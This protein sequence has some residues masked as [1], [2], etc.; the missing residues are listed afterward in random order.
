M[1]FKLVIPCAVPIAMVFKFGFD[2]QWNF[3]GNL[4]AFLEMQTVTLEGYE[5]NNGKKIPLKN[6]ENKPTKSNS[7]SI[8]GTG[9]ASF[10]LLPNASVGVQFGGSLGA[11]IGVT[12]TLNLIEFKGE[13]GYDTKMPGEVYKKATLNSSF[14]INPFITFYVSP[15]GWNFWDQTVTFDQNWKVYDKSMNVNPELYVAEVP[16]RLI[17]DISS[18]WPT[19]EFEYGIITAGIGLGTS[20]YLPRAAIFMNDVSGKNLLGHIKPYMESEYTPIKS[21]EYY[22]FKYNFFKENQDYDSDNKYIV[23]PAL[24]DPDN[25]EYT[26][27]TNHSYT[28]GTPEVSAEIVGGAQEGAWEVDGEYNFTDE[29]GL[30]E[31]R[32]ALD[33]ETANVREASDWGVMISIPKLGIEDKM[34]SLKR[35]LSGSNSVKTVGFTFYSDYVADK[36]KIDIEAS[37]YMVNKISGEMSFGFLNGKLSLKYPMEWHQHINSLGMRERVDYDIE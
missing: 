26:Y 24:Y 21:S 2:I 35:T 31:Y 17:T 1:G 23:V 8:V 6:P 11:D 15:F 19:V 22:I 5:Y 18:D 9:S 25:D 37:T 27:Y 12:G 3:N 7:Y 13:L 16:G 30:I 20:K 29:A 36:E 33:F 34:I 4:A 10:S 28:V 32:F 14:V